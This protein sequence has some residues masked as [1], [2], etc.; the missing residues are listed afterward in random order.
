MTSKLMIRNLGVA[1]SRENPV[2]LYPYPVMLSYDNNNKNLLYTT[3][4]QT[5]H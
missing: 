4:T 1:A 3:R 5:K 2:R